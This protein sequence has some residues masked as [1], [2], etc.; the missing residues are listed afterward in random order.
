[1]QLMF[2]SVSEND[3][4][5]KRQNN[6]I[7]G[8]DSRKSRSRGRMGPPGRSGRERSDRDDKQDSIPRDDIV[9]YT[10]RKF[11]RLQGDFKHLAGL[12]QS[13][14]K[15]RDMREAQKSRPQVRR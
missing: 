15:D 2:P 4:T 5:W 9:R 7:C 12:A 6:N 14:K 13:L 1:M 11:M 3:P 10:D 8:V